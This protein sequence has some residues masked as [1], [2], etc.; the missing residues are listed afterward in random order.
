MTKGTLESR[1]DPTS[2]RF[3]DSVTEV[4]NLLLSLLSSGVGHTLFGVEQDHVTDLQNERDPNLTLLNNQSCHQQ[5]RGK[6]VWQVLHCRKA[7]NNMLWGNEA[8]ANFVYLI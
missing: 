6:D 1:A 8:F 4:H 2:S 5:S 3:I 7:I